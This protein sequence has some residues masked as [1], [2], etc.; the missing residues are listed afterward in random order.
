MYDK[1]TTMKD[2]E[3]KTLQFIEQFVAEHGFSPKLQEIAKGIGITSRGTV[4]RY[5]DGL[6]SQGYLQKDN[7]KSRGLNLLKTTVQGKLVSPLPLLGFIAAGKPI[8]A[9]EQEEVLDLST[10]L[11]GTDH[12]VL[13]VR[14]YSMQDEGILDGDYVICHSQKT[15]ENGDIVVALIDEHEATL[16][17]LYWQPPDQIKL[18]PANQAMQPQFYHIDRITIQGVVKGLFRGEQ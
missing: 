9:V 7:K 2:S 18:V 8:E 4:S 15:A 17:R 6:I 1:G 3:R 13:R 11:Q 10:L 14:G 16:K 5:I 12:Y